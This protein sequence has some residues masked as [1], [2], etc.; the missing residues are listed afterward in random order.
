MARYCDWNTTDILEMARKW[1]DD[2]LIG[3]GSLLWPGSSVWT[4][5][6]LGAFKSRFAD[7]PDESEKGFLD[8]LKI[9]LAGQPKEVTQIA[10]EVLL[11]YYLFP[12]SVKRR[13][14]ASTIRMIA[15]WVDLN[16]DADQSFDFFA[17][18]IGNPG[19]AYLTRQW[20]ETVYILNVG[21]ALAGM[22]TEERKQLLSDPIAF[23]SF[24][25]TMPKGFGPQSRHALLHLLFPDY[26]ERIVSAE[27]K[28]QIAKAFCGVLEE[29]APEDVDDRLYAIRKKLEVLLNKDKLDFYLSPLGECWRGIDNPDNAGDPLDGLKMKKQ[30]V[31]FGPP[32]TGK[33]WTARSIAQRLIRQEL[34]KSRSW[35]VAEY[36]K[37]RDEANLLIE[38]RVSRVQ[39]HPGYSYEDFIRGLQLV[40]GGRTEYRNGALLNI[41]DE[42]NKEPDIPYVLILDELNRSDLSRTMGEA[43]SAM[44]DRNSSVMLA[45]QDDR[46]LRIPQNLYFIGTMNLIDQS[47]EHVDFALRRRFLWFPMGF[48]KDDFLTVSRYRWNQK[49]T[50]RKWS[51][52]AEEFE[53]L[54]ARAQKLNEVI[55]SEPVLGWQYEIGH[56]YFCEAVDFVALWMEKQGNPQTILFNKSKKAKWP[57]TALWN[58]SIRPL[59]E[60][61]LSGVDNGDRDRLLARLQAILIDGTGVDESR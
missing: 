49:T 9:Q 51:R 16:L 15:S 48:S 23:R 34:L 57:V 14:K 18:G 10:C 36:F 43:F 56:T 42:A 21:V 7:D 11:V 55:G 19:M 2:C 3:G 5:E 35:G 44:E 41:I 60:Q 32:G 28:N 47:L 33:T 37:R 13:T 46:E 8:K 29:D 12:I 1:K 53:L 54:A 45:G 25:D 61:Y 59:I 39:F 52:H 22:S 4:T 30:V 17:E 58:F 26:Y 50:G 38:S 40:D 20:H 6:N 31:L 27:H 24:L